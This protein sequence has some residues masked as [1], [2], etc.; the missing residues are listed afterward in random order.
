MPRIALLFQ[1]DCKFLTLTNVVMRIGRCCSANSMRDIRREP[2]LTD[3]YETVAQF[4]RAESSAYIYRVSGRTRSGHKKRPRSQDENVQ[5]IEI[6]SETPT[7]LR[8]AQERQGQ[9]GSVILDGRTLRSTC[10]SSSRG[11]NEQVRV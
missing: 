6:E 8:I 9:L 4:R 10:E 1:D 2:I 7:G 5:F 3:T 11:D